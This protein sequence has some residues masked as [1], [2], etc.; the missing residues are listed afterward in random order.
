M[1]RKTRQRELLESILVAH[2]VHYKP[3]DLLEKAETE[4]SGVISQA[5]LYR[6]L[7]DMEANGEIQ[8]ITLSDGSTIYDGNIVPHA[9][10]YCQACNTLFDIDPLPQDYL[11]MISDKYG[12]TISKVNVVINGYCE[13]C[14]KERR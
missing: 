5:T 1:Q 7:S 10:F 6:T 2:K 9:H 3:R 11:E 8:S 12:V 14:A 4:N 13:H